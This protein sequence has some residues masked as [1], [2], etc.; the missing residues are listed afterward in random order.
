MAY[1]N[2]YGEEFDP[3]YE[4]IPIYCQVCGEQLTEYGECYRCDHK[5]C[6]K[7]NMPVSGC[8]TNCDCEDCKKKRLRK[9]E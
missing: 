8:Y 5:H 1:A 4:N 9:E 6:D 2:I 7:C 3:H